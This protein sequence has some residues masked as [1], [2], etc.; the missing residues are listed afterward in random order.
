MSLAVP[1]IEGEKVG[2]LRIRSMTHLLTPQEAS[3]SLANS[4]A[5]TDSL[6][7]PRGADVDAL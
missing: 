5:E 1:A 3:A 6:S 2:P 7:L 4:H